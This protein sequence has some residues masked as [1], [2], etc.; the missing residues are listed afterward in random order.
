MLMSSGQMQRVP[1]FIQ[2]AGRWQLRRQ[3]QPLS[4]STQRVVRPEGAADSEHR[5]VPCS[6]TQLQ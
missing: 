3:S 5:A 2:S 1:W 6:S 4:T